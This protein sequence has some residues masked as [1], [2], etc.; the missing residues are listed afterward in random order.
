MIWQDLLVYTNFAWEKTP[1]NLKREAIYDDVLA[2]LDISWGG[3]NLLNHR[4]D[5]KIMWNN[6]VPDVG[7]VNHA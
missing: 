5:F 1:K 2:K 6:S 7:L 3:N 4:L